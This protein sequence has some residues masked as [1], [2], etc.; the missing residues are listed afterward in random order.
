LVVTVIVTVLPASSATGLYVNEKGDVLAEEGLTVPKP[1][2]V[3]VTLVAVP[4]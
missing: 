2:S 3:I 4:P 1:F